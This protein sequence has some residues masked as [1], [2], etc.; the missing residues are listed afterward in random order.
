MTQFWKEGRWGYQK[1]KNN[2]SLDFHFGLEPPPILLIML[3]NCMNYL[4]LSYNFS[5]NR[6]TGGLGSFLKLVS[7]YSEPEIECFLQML[8]S[9]LR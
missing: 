2:F 5:G 8:K 6:M 4:N 9:S 7:K 3:K 1:T